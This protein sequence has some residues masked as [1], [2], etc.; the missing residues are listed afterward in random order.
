MAIDN[1]FNLEG[2]FKGDFTACKNDCNNRKDCVAFQHEEFGCIDNCS[3]G[4]CFLKGARGK[5]PTGK[6]VD[7][8]YT[9]IDIKY[10]LE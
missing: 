2:R 6:A 7:F 3:A 8:N 1:S 5:S 9:C 10:L 4:N